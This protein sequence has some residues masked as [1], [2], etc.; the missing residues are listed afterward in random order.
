MNKT[1]RNLIPHNKDNSPFRV[2]LA[3]DDPVTARAIAASLQEWG[4]D[5]LLA[6]NGDKAWEIIQ[7]EDVHLA[8]IDWM[9]PGLSGLELCQRIRDKTQDEEAHYIYI[10]LLTG[11]DEQSDIIKGFLAGA[12]DY[13]TKPF[14]FE[15][16]KVRLLKGVRIIER[17]ET[18]LR[19][20][21]ID[22]LTRLWNRKK[23][24]QFFHEEVE[25]GHREGQ[26]TGV[27]MVD[28]DQF[29]K[30]NDTYGHLIGDEVLKEVANRLSRS[31]REYDKI[32]RYGGDE[33]LLIIPS[34][35][36]ENLRR[37][38]RRVRKVVAHEPIE[39]DKGPLKVTIS[40]GGA[41]SSSFPQYS[42]LNLIQAA[43]EALLRA[44]AAGRNHEAFTEK[45]KED[46]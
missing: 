15:E 28:I 13:V 41:S 45:Q 27:I 34:C 25:R 38:A 43:D 37:I 39:T 14:D 4:F 8:I 6:R 12:D 10:I 33:F 30:I 26:P 46:I 7:K 31:V 44:K 3:E 16:L 29:K 21:S 36:L 5:T 40:C 20:A 17:E 24:M 18:R 22:S 2:L 42:A 23:I 1:V 32:G 35:S 9:M 11:R 19:L